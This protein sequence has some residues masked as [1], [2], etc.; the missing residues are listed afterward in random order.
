MT[1]PTEVALSLPLEPSAE[2]QQAE[3]DVSVGP[4]VI[5]HPSAGIFQEPPIQ[6]SEWRMFMR[7]GDREMALRHEDFLRGLEE[8]ERLSLR[9]RIRL[10]ENDVFRVKSRLFLS[11]HQIS[12]PPN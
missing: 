12:S 8:F 5:I 10:L 7:R 11:S 9:D 4:L 3:G 6:S 1:P 2:A